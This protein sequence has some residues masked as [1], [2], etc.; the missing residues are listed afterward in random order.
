ML[1]GNRIER[2]ETE[3]VKLVKI[4]GALPRIELVDRKKHRLA[5]LA[6]QIDGHA[7][8]GI[9]SAFAVEQK[10]NDVGFRHR[11]P[12]LSLHALVERAP[13]ARI[14]AAGIDDQ[15]PPPGP[16]SLGIVAIAGHARHVVDNRFARADQTVEKR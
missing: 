11:A 9:E 8:Q 1:G 2:I 14:Q 5:R 7:I 16:Q 10:Y 4:I 15:I 12:T 3:R 13:A 6:Q